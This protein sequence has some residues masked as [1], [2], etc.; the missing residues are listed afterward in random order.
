MFTDPD[1]LK[2]SDPGRV[3]GNVAFTYLEAFHP[4]QDEV[5]ALKERYKR[6]GLGDT[7]I[8]EI[9]NASLQTL[10]GPMRERRASFK[11]ADLLEI[12]HLGSQTAR[13]VAQTTVQDMREAMHLQYF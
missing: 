2:V 8:K 6:G 11:D 13:S 5:A 4:D 1:H 10:L 9:L 7:A 12:L 3:E